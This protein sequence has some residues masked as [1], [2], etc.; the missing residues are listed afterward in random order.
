MAGTILWCTS[1]LFVI[2]EIS[3]KI[4]DFEGGRSIKSERREQR[5][6]GGLIR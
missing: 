4:L 1:C 3:S 6:S 2:F 5:D